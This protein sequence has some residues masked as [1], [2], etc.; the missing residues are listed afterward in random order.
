MTPPANM[1]IEDGLHVQHDQF[2]RDEHSHRPSMGRVARRPGC[3]LDIATVPHSCPP[4]SLARR[5]R[6]RAEHPRICPWNT[7]A[8]PA[9]S[10]CAPAS[11]RDQG[12]P[13]NRTPPCAR[14]GQR[15]RPAVH[16][17]SSNERSEVFRPLGTAAILQA[18][19]TAA[20]LRALRRVDAPEPNA[21]AVNFECVAV[22]HAGLSDQIGR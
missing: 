17:L 13:P 20:Q 11:R 1:F 6:H 22:D 10:R 8:S 2:L 4:K 12:R 14:I 19:I 3:K 9:R 5:A 18:V 15:N 7:V 21:R 16:H